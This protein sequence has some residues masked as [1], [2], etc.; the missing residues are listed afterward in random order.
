M[1]TLF[2][3][4]SVIPVIMAL[5]LALGIS[6]AMTPFVKKLAFKIGAVDVPKDNRRM[7]DHPIP[8]LGGLA[9]FLGFI[10]AVLLLIPLDTA[11]KDECADKCTADCYGPSNN[12]L[13][14]VC[15]RNET[16]DC[17]IDCTSDCV[18]LCHVTDTKRC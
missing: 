14:A 7:H 15:S 10:I 13:F 6:F 3:R 4:T 18:D 16:C 8:R 12:C 5:A 2:D 9:I 1:T 11:K 17:C